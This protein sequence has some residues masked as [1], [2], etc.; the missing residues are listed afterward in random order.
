MRGRRD[1]SGQMMAALVV[2]LAITLLAFVVVALVPV[3]A[4]TNEKTRSQTAADAAALAGAEAVRSRWVDLDTNPA[5]LFFQDDPGNGGGRGFHLGVRGT[6]GYGEASDYA[7]RN[8]A[9]LQTYR[10]SPGAGRVYA[11]VENTYAAYPE[12]GEARSEATAE[13]DVDFRACRWNPPAPTV[14][15]I[16]STPPG[17][18]TFDATL[19]CGRWSADYVVTNSTVAQYKIASYGGSSSPGSSYDDL[20]PRLVE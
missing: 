11:E 4:A 3:G 15:P 12:R 19:T 8:D 18:L 14:P 10:V 1:D 16:E 5:R 13:M 6:D 7:R 20:E 17:P 2:G 9:D